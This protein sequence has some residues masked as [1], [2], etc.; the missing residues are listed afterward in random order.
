MDDTKILQEFRCCVNKRLLCKA[1]WD[2]QVEIMNPSN[3]VVNYVWPTR[4]SQEF[5]LRGKDFSAKAS[6][7]YCKEC[8]RLLAKAIWT[9]LVVEIKCRYCHNI[10]LYDLQEIR[11]PRMRQLSSLQKERILENN[12]S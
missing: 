12:K 8:K 5:W 10:N 6:T 9:T 4:K 2:G 7:L 3:R 11:E 1:H